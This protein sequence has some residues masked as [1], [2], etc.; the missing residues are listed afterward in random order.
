MLI[1]GDFRA[2]P[3]TV[4][5]DDAAAVLPAVWI[6]EV[7]SEWET[8]A[9]EATP[10]LL[11]PVVMPP[12]EQD[13]RR[14][15]EDVRREPLD[16]ETV[17][18]MSAS[19]S[20]R[21]GATKLNPRNSSYALALAGTPGESVCVSVYIFFC[22]EQGREEMRKSVNSNINVKKMEGETAGVVVTQRQ[23]FHFVT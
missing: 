2:A 20:R 4:D 13:V 7:V 3:A 11:V 23:V 1:N 17:L 21:M 19:S 14:A 5:D 8:S 15:D 10:E 18:F 12:A 16:E 9:L 22:V 6:L